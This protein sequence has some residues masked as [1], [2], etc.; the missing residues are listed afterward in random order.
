MRTKLTL[1]CLVLAGAG[2]TAAAVNGLYAQAKTPIYVVTEIGVSN[3][4]AYAKEYASKAQALIKASGGRFVAIG[5]VGGTGAGKIAA[6]DG[7]APKRSTIQVWDSMEQ[8]QAYRNKP[9]FKEIRAIGEKYATFRTF[10]VDGV[11]HKATAE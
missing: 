8:Y 11:P 3:P 6:F 10:T 4:E 1:T 9:E 5:G 2:F 7:E